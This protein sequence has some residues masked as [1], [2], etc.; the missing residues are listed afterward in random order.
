MAEESNNE[1]RET[2]QANS[3][4]AFWK[5]Y[6]TDVEPCNF[7][8]M[9]DGI[10]CPVQ[11][12]SVSILL[13]AS[14]QLR[15]FCNEHQL[16]LSDILQTAWAFVLCSYVGTDEACFSYLMFTDYGKEEIQ[17]ATGALAGMLIRRVQLTRTIPLIETLKGV[18]N[19]FL[20]CLPYQFRLASGIHHATRLCEERTFNTAVCLRRRC[21]AVLGSPTLRKLDEPY[22]DP[23]DGGLP[24][25][26]F[27][28]AKHRSVY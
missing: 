27:N 23:Q 14:L 20:Y 3:I 25:V 26:C 22:F 13:D 19:Q 8:V 12:R 24:M 4:V 18:Q 16:S 17:G 21:S 15:H 11:E 9:N 5:K 1:A 2:L 10:D 7:P 6:L 28:R